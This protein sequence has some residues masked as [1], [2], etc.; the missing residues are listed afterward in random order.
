MKEAHYYIAHC[1]ASA[2]SSNMLVIHSRALSL[3]ACNVIPCHSLR[4]LKLA[5][6]HPPLQVLAK[7]SKMIPVM[8]IGTVLH[9]K[10]YS[11]LEYVCCLL[12]SGGVVGQAMWE[13][14]GGAGWD[15]GRGGRI[16]HKMPSWGGCSCESGTAT[17]RRACAAGGDGM[18]GSLQAGVGARACCL[19][20]L[21][22]QPCRPWS[23]PAQPASPS[24][25]SSPPTR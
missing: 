23:P 5:P 17:P 9:G 12:I 13:G 1:Y 3:Q 19:L 21:L 4:L 7:S 2:S 20:C 22:P 18:L 24:L 10:S 16:A 14:A 15:G 6:A 8:L 11:L 25:G